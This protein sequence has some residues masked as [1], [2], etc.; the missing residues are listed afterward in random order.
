MRD[1]VLT[2]AS[3]AQERFTQ[4]ASYASNVVSSMSWIHLHAET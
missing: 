3:R 1:A 4:Y 2:G